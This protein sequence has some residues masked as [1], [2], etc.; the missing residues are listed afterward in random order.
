MTDKELKKL[1]RSDLLRLL[2]EQSRQMEAMKAEAADREAALCEENR[3][4]KA[5]LED[6]TLKV[7]NAGSLAE[8]CLTVN[9]V[10]GAAQLAAD[11]YLENIRSR[12]EDQD[13]FLA[14]REA[15]AQAKVDA[16]LAQAQADCASQR[17]AA[18][19]ECAAKRL[20]TQ[21]LCDGATEEARQKID[22]YWDDLSGR[23]QG[24][25]DAHAGL[26][27]LLSGG[28]MTPNLSRTA[29]QVVLLGDQPGGV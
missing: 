12:T 20:E 29:M 14:E 18:E 25:Y 21:R 10:M 11:Q 3:Q 2:V 19:A 16:M 4:L 1:K 8:A 22:A 5:Q 15:E 6:R 23:L 7:E 28:N 9:G 27:Q 17:S 26:Y 13:T 24:F